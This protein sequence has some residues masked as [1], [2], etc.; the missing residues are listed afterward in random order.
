MEFHIDREQFLKALQRTQ[1]V[2]E[3]RNTMP[4]LGYVLLEA[5]EDQTVTLLATDT[6][7][8]LK[9]LLSAEVME[10]GSIAIL[11]SRLFEIVRELPRGVPIRLRQEEDSYRCYLTC[12]RSRFVLQGLPGDE[13]PEYQD[14]SSLVRFDIES[15]TLAA[16]IN[17]THFSMSQDESRFALNGVC[18]QLEPPSEDHA[19]TI[20]RLVATDSHRLSLVE[21]ALLVVPEG[22]DALREV[23]LPRKGVQEVRRLLEVGEGLVS[24]E[25]SH[26]HIRCIRDHTV[27]TSKLVSGRFPNYRKVIPANND[28]LLT[29]DK[30]E[31]QLVVKR[32]AAISNEK[33][34]S[35]Q[36][37]IESGRLIVT[38]NNPDQETA[39]EEM[40][41]Q[42]DGPAM[43]I[44]FN[45]RYIQDILAVIAGHSVRFHLKDSEGPALVTDPDQDHYRFVLMPMRV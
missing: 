33:S 16:M 24:V 19:E 8:S 34:R 30:E 7:I 13:F 32:I 38:T 37:I 1:G 5:S 29:V 14:I 41:I 35:L 23:I 21:E 26:Q 10:P 3:L 25:L 17:R 9:S 20:L 45:A 39:E 44:G 42:Y 4:I 2:A 36:L 15:N 28:L 11:A 27:L 31:L 40:V 12:G 18:L 6:E 22:L 43:V